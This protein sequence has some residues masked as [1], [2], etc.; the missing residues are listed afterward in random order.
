MLSDHNSWSCASLEACVSCGVSSSFGQSTCILSL[1]SC[2]EKNW[3]SEYD[4]PFRFKGV[5]DCEVIVQTVLARNYEDVP[6]LASSVYVNSRK[7]P[8]HLYFTR[9][10]HET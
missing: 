6:P 2:V 9:D 4:L 8:H 5:F 3:S 10:R 1:A 7:N